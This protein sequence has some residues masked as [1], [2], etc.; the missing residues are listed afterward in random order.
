[1]RT[2]NKLDARKSRRL[3]DWILANRS[4]LEVQATTL[5]EVA[6][7]AAKA[8]E[9]VVTDRN[10]HSAAEVVGVKIKSRAGPKPKLLER[11]ERLEEWASK[12]GYAPPLF[13]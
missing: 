11:L 3:Q 6:E 5:P 2:Q 13:S 7:K 1:M 8:L 9:M 10:V 4:L 12:N